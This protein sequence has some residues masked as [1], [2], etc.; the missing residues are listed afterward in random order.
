MLTSNT[1]TSKKNNN[2][3]KKNGD[4]EKKEAQS[5]SR[6]RLSGGRLGAGLCVCGGGAPVFVG[7]CV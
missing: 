6:P 4:I 1:G 3:E 7:V 2:I 5:R